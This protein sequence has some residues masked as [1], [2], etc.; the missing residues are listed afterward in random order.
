VKTTVELSK[1]LKP[2]PSRSGLNYYVKTFGCQMNEHDSERIAGLFEHDGMIKALSEDEADI[3]FVNTCTIR[4]NADDKLYGTLGHLKKWKGEK[5]NRKLLVGG[6]AAQKDKE[7]VRKRA[8]WVDVVIGTHNLTNIVNLLNQSEDW[9]PV[10]EV[11]DEIQS[12]P[13]D[14]PSIRESEV[15][16]WLTIQIGCNNS[17]TFCIVPSVRGPEISRRP[18]DIVNEATAMVESG[19][20]EITLLGQN[21]NSYGRDLRINGAARPYFTELLNELNEIDDLKR[22]R[23]TSPHPK[24]FKEDTLK[25][26]DRLTKVTNQIHMPLQSGSNKI[27]RK[28]QRGY[29]QEKYLEKVNL[30]KK[31]ITN[32]S[33]TTDIIVGFPG[34]TDEDF[35]E[36]LNVINEGQF[37]SVY[38]FKFSPRPGTKANSMQDEYVSKSKIDSRFMELKKI[39]TDISHSRLQRFIGTHQHVL[40]EKY[41][42]KT[43]DFLTGKIDGGQTTHIKAENVSIGDFV[44]VEI[45]DATPFALTAVLL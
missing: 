10:T 28:M 41:S 44:E 35:L 23:F 21:V 15:S 14:A 34:E 5:L 31:T 20:K 2:K 45:V 7:L 19:V 38:M 33:L 29:T 17:C 1:T 37:D 32:V 25:A 30:A 3:L 40:I 8:P 6:C 22:I 12:L 27:L 13:T 9:G 11:I 36:T 24:D 16:A 39:Q 26:V 18:S 43:N 4:E 42:K